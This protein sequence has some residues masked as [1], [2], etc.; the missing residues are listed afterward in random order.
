MKDPIDACCAQNLRN[1]K[2]QYARLQEDYKSKLCEVSKLRADAD[3]LKKELREAKSQKDHME[4][5]LQDMK[6]RVKCI[7]AERDELMGNILPPVLLIIT[8]L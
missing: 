1:L 7:E 6:E 4:I 3:C 2:E 8:L 5:S